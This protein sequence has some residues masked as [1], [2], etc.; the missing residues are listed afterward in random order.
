MY[1]TNGT[2]WVLTR[3]WYWLYIA[4]V[5]FFILLNV[6][7]FCV[8]VC[9]YVRECLSVSPHARA[10][11][12]AHTHSCTPTLT[13]SIFINFLRVLSSR[14]HCSYNRCAQALLAII[15]GAY[16]EVN[17]VSPVWCEPMGV[18]HRRASSDGSVR[19]PTSARCT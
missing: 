4:I 12:R 5:V 19:P 6:R 16:E 13:L 3:L 7:W 14:D 2:L 10:H 18:V 17:A 9:L 8:P 11:A 1:A 15:V